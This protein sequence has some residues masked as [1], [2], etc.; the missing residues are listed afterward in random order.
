MWLLR[1]RVTRSRHS[2]SGQQVTGQSKIVR[3]LLSKRYTKLRP[4]G[5]ST[6][7]KKF[8]SFR[9]GSSRKSNL[10]DGTSGSK[11]KEQVEPTSKIR[12]SASTS[13]SKRSVIEK[14]GDKYVD[15]VWSAAS[16]AVKPIAGKPKVPMRRAMAFEKMFGE[17]H[18]TVQRAR[19]LNALHSSLIMASINRPQPSGR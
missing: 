6:P 3:L 19:S 2:G 11:V 9:F 5:D 1:N 13:S 10:D 14:F 7:V 18:D 4:A 16:H 12:R 8:T 17:P 15:V